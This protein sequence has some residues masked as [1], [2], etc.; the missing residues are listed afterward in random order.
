MRL[1]DA[2]A[3]MHRML[4]EKREA[5]NW[6][7]AV[8]Y[9]DAIK[10]VEC[11]IGEAPTVAE[12][13]NATRSP[14]VKTADRLPDKCE[15]YTMYLTTKKRDWGV[16]QVRGSFIKEHTEL[17]PWWMPIPPLPEVEK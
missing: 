9:C 11:M 7:Y 10:R 14:W 2:D 15:Y 12:D 13:S 17:C 6:D 4:E 16:W 8:G 5:P 1:I 3:L